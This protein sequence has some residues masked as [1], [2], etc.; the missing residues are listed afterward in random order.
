MIF[1]N[2]PHLLRSVLVAMAGLLLPLTTVLAQS[3]ETSSDNLQ[4]GS[5]IQTDSQSSL[6]RI[7]IDRSTDSLD[8]Q[9]LFSDQTLNIN[10]GVQVSP[11]EGLNLTAD[12]WRLEVEDQPPGSALT[13]NGL[14]SILPGIYLE[15]EPG[16]VFSLDQ[17]L[18]NTNVEANGVDL[19]ASYVWNTDKI[20]QFTLSSRASYIYD[21]NQRSNIPE[22]AALLSGE[23]LGLTSSPDLQGSLTLTWQLGNHS[24]SAV[25]NYFDSFKD[26][27]D[28][29][30]EE[31]N[32][33]VD[34]ITKSP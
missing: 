5:G 17:R 19:G 28:L 30:L 9:G 16:A 2:S 12:A 15:S 23:S 3:L 33:L 20:G 14:Q 13:N 34:N 21:M 4:V 24:A 29:N 18:Q 32:E 25:T 7:N 22:A 11:A 6:S 8:Y 26:I 10:F 27:G 1:S 31:I